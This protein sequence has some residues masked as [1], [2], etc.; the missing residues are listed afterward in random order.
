MKVALAY[1][2]GKDSTATLLWLLKEGHEVTP[3]F[4]DTGA[5]WPETYQYLDYIEGKLNLKIDRINNGSLRELVQRYRKWPHPHFGRFCTRQLKIV[6][7]AR[8]LKEHEDIDCLAM[9]IRAA[10]SISRSRR[11]EWDETGKG[12]YSRPI[13]LPILNWTRE[14]VLEYI[15]NS[16]LKLNP[17]Y[18]YVGRANCA[19]CPLGSPKGLAMFAK[20]HPDLAEEWATLEENHISGYWQHGVNL[21]DI[22]RGAIAQSAFWDDDEWTGCMTDGFCD[23]G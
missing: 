20:V 12:S 22:T 9:G 3:C 19:V 8:W 13:W 17:V 21:R 6:P 2:G 7:Q 1:S 10:E 11:V 4:Q 15:K 18:K 14:K 16:G 23:L 5:E